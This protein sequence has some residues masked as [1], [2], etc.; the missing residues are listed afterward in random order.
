[1]MEKL[2]ELDVNFLFYVGAC[3]SELVDT[4]SN[5]LIRSYCYLAYRPNSTLIGDFYMTRTT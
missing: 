1:M 4:Y 5:L 3:S 2:F